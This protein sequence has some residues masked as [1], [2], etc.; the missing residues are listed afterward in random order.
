MSSTV[1]IVDDNDEMRRVIRSMVADLVEDI[2]E[3]RDGAEALATY[4]RQ[5]PDW[6]FLDIRLPRVDGITAAREIHALH[7]AARI[8]IVTAYDDREFRT[9]A[10]NAGA[11]DYVLKD[12]LLRLRTILSP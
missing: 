2:W 7:P 8:V 4:R 12:D 10:H 1:L 6:V 11:I 9:A 3:C 5:R